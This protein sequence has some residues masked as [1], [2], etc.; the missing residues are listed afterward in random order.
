M[1]NQSDENASSAVAKARA[2]YAD[3]VGLRAAMQAIPY[4]GGPLD[5]LLAGSAARIHLRRVEEFAHELHQRL[6][7]VELLAANLK[8]DAFADL[9]LTTFEKVAR[10]RSEGKRSRFARII[11][12]QVIEGARWEEAES[13]VRLL[14]DLED[15]HLEVLGVA[16]AAP[17]DTKGF[18][19]L[20]VI[21]IATSPFP[22]DSGNG[23]LA[24]SDALP[25]YGSPALRMACAELMARGLLHDEGIGR[26]DLD[27]MQCFVPTDLADWFAAWIVDPGH[28]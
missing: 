28:A 21:T 16:F 15:V 1:T 22:D 11:T 4:I 18:E 23:P 9:V 19:G 2:K 27:A 8:D 6:E 25:H 7:G 14:G 26:W 24:L 17:S 13:A 20:R 5:T 12:R 3:T 10:T